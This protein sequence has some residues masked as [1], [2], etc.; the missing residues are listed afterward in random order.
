MATAE[1]DRVPEPGVPTLGHYLA[2]AVGGAVGGSLRYA[3][4]TVFGAGPGGFPWVILAENLTGAFLLGLALVLLAAVPP[5]LGPAAVRRRRRARVVHDLLE[6]RRRRRG[7]P[8]G[9]RGGSRDRLLVRESR[10]RPGRGGTRD[11]PRTGARRPGGGDTV[12]F[13]LVAAAA[14]C[15]AVARYA[16]QVWIESRVRRR[17]PWGTW[18]VNVSGSFALGLVVGAAV[19]H[20][21]APAYA[22][23]LGT[24]FLGAYTTFSTWMYETVVLLERRRYGAAL[25][26]LLGSWLTG[27]LAAGAGLALALRA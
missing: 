15:G 21:L 26:Y 11:C 16:V 17:I 25:W 13:V 14:A 5:P 19:Q 10:A 8:A 27:V 1:A 24:G 23:V 9:R 12:T 22:T 3:F 20:D 7:A 4:L 18:A 6:S 2:V